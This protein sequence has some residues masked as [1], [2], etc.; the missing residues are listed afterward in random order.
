MAIGTFVQATE[1]ANS[2]EIK[3]N[4]MVAECNKIFGKAVPGGATLVDTTSAQALSGPKTMTAP[5]INSATINDSAIDG[6]SA[7]GLTNLRI[8]SGGAGEMRLQHTS[9]LTADRALL[10]ELNDANRGLS[11]GGNFTTAGN[12][13]TAGAFGLTL[14]ATALTNVTLPTTGTL[15]TLAGTE[16]FTGKTLTSPTI[17][18]GTKTGGATIE[19]TALSIRSTGAA[20]DVSFV[21][22]EVLTGDKTL[23]FNLAD[24]NRSLV[25]GGNFS[26]GGSVSFVGSSAAQFTIGGATIATF[27]TGTFTVADTSS[28]QTFALKTLTEPVINTATINTSNMVG[29]TAT[30]IT[31]LSVTSAGSGKM[32]ILCSTSLSSDRILIIDTG[33]VNRGVTI[34]GDLSFG[35]AFSTIGGHILNLTTTATT[36]ITLPT[37]GTLTT[38]EVVNPKIVANTDYV[39]AFTDS[40]YMGLPNTPSDQANNFAGGTMVFTEVARSDGVWNS[41]EIYSF[42]GRTITLGV[43]TKSGNTYTQVRSAT[44]FTTT[45]GLQTYNLFSLK[46]NKGELI[47]YTGAGG[48]SIDF[49]IVGAG[50][51]LTPFVSGTLSGGSFDDDTVS[52][53]NQMQFRATIRSLTEVATERSEREAADDALAFL[54]SSSSPEQVIGLPRE[55][56]GAPSSSGAAGF[57]FV[58]DPA[59]E[60][61]GILRTLEVYSG[62]A[63]TGSI[64][65]YSHSG[66]TFTLLRNVATVSFEAN[67]M[68]PFDLNFDVSEGEMIGITPS[69]GGWS[70]YTSV[71]SGSR[72]PYYLGT[73]SSGSFTDVAPDTTLELEIRVT[74]QL[75][76]E[77]SVNI[78]NSDKF[79]AVGQSFEPGYDQPEDLN[80]HNIASPW[81]RRQ[82]DIWAV[83]GT[84]WAEILAYLRGGTVGYG[85][86]FMAMRATVVGLYM[87]KNDDIDN[88]DP[89]DFVA[90]GIE[91]VRFIQNCG[92]SEVIVFTEFDNIYA[93]GGSNLYKQICD[94]TGARYVNAVAHAKEM[95]RVPPTT[96]LFQGTYGAAAGW[97]MGARSANLR[98]D[99]TLAALNS[100]ERPRQ[101]VKY[102]SKRDIISPVADIDDLIFSNDVEKNGI[103]KEVPGGGI[104]FGP[105]DE[106]YY[107]RLDLSG[108]Y[109]PNV[110]VKLSERLSLS[111]GG[112]FDFGDYALVHAGI[113]ASIETIRSVSMTIDDEDADIYVLDWKPSGGIDW[114]LLTQA[115]PGKVRLTH[116]DLRGRF[117]D[118]EIYF[119]IVNEADGV[120]IREPKIRFSAA[121]EGKFQRIPRGP[122]AEPKGVT[123]MAQELVGI[124]GPWSE[125]GGVTVDAAPW[126]QLP[127]NFGGV[128]YTGVV[129]LTTM[130]KITQTLT[131]STDAT[132]DRQIAVRV[133]AIKAPA[134]KSDPLAGSILISADTVNHGEV[135]VTLIDASAQR[136]EYRCKSK[137]AA[138]PQGLW[139][140]WQECRPIIPMDCA[141]FDIEISATGS[142]IYVAEVKTNFVEA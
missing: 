10:I 121:Q 111:N 123:L 22:T 46:V 63:G 61:D 100:L 20:Y 104:H 25:L 109:R 33:D 83:G 107:D 73:L 90:D 44:A 133:K 101:W 40:Y 65:I 106:G 118:G 122:L 31:N 18:G 127:A 58:F 112:T 113:P 86:A 47:G 62:T 120:V 99:V 78:L 43:F 105:G 66:S 24:A 81:D 39:N 102:Y 12:L 95:V 21:S 7:V 6:G 80:W 59:F 98:A 17:N 13:T 45:G 2:A 71:G 84:T 114:T 35:G 64:D 68:N 32:R 138:H 131:F 55:P 52:T 67:A 142:D 103:F 96:G 4:Q 49:A 54:I 97:H 3:L 91:C 14:T 41:V 38:D 79:I 15:A 89:V 85:R 94:A 56:T 19:Q 119:L 141:A 70:K 50:A 23:F 135:I 69:T 27:P 87:G 1:T 132:K 108:T 116:S 9:A 26:I 5:I 37:T 76:A 115:E 130:K 140:N 16:T 128:T 137:N 36:N 48:G 139:Y 75:S 117:N 134:Q 11:L 124:T 34:G 110:V 126:F 30:G 125:T 129:N 92:A 77:Q 51:S 72:T 57:T 60:A 82:W 136:F 29:G 42:I 53:V 93:P 74:L 88:T 28:A 8:T